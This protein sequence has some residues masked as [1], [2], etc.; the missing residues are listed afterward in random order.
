MLR[1]QQIFVGDEPLQSGRYYPTAFVTEQGVARKYGQH[2][3]NHIE[4]AVD[5]M[6][7]YL[8][9]HRPMQAELKSTF[10]AV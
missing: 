10:I 3:E 5:A 7:A 9:K 8:V 1:L 4:R 6:R 2:R